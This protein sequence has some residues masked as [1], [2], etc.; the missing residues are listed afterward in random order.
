MCNNHIISKL[1]TKINNYF[2]QKTFKVKKIKLEKTI[3]NISFK[4]RKE[5][6]IKSV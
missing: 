1:N 2:E 4:N 3:N 6:Y 5:F